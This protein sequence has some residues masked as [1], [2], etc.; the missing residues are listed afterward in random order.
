LSCDKYVSLLLSAESAYDEEFKPNGAKC[1]VLFHDIQDEYADREDKVTFDHDTTF[2]IDCPVSTIQAC[3]TNFWSKTLAKFTHAKARIPSDKQFGLDAASKAIRDHRDDKAKS[4]ILRY[5]KPEPTQAGFHPP[6][7]ILANLPLVNLAN[8]TSRP[9]LTSTT[10]QP[11]TLISFWLNMMIPKL[12]MTQKI[13][14]SSMQ[15]S[16]EVMVLFPLVISVALFP[17]HYEYFVSKHEALLAHSMSLID[18]GANGGVA[19]D[20]VRIIFRTNHTVDIKGID[21]HHVNNIGI[22]TIGGVKPNMVPSLLS[23]TN[24]SYLV[25][26]HPSIHLDSLN[27][28]IMMSTILQM[29]LL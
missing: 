18:R 2:D 27:G 13:F 9:R 10:F 26:V 28:I 21:N 25:K 20:D 19:G 24:M 16:R 23:C 1:H 5:T 8:H 14:A 29:G 17:I 3:A 15:R 11:M 7:L 12:L 6:D 22:G 4:I